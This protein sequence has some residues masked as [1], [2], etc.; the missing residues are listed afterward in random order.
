MVKAGRLV[1]T[2]MKAKG[3]AKFPISALA[4]AN[5][6]KRLKFRHLVFEDASQK[7]I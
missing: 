1:S 3:V 2:A 7:I 6:E 4:R 5:Q